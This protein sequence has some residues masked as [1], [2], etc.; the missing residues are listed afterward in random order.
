MCQK[1][2]VASNTIAMNEKK[3]SLSLMRTEKLHGILKEEAKQFAGKKTADHKQS[4][5]TKRRCVETKKQTSAQ[6]MKS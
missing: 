6:Q 3:R 2:I 4:L 1:Q 5:C